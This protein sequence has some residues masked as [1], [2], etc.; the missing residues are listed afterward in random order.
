MS[1]STTGGKQNRSG[2]HADLVTQIDRAR[3]SL[4]GTVSGLSDEEARRRTTVS[5][6]C[7]GGL[8]KHVTAV[9]QMWANFL[10]EGRSALP[11]FDSLTEADWARHAEQFRMMP[12]ETLDALLAGYDV[13]NRRFDTLIATQ[14]DLDT[15]IALPDSPFFTEQHWTVRRVLLHV[16]LDTAQHAG[17]ADIIRE[18]LDG[19]RSTG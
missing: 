4:R 6:L 12:G 14:P 9:E 11:D 15:T 17:H 16:V 18:A 1:E 2:E 19:K 10:A 7:L 5:D 13:S 8:I 3:Q